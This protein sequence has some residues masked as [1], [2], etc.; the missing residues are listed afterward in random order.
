VEERGVRFVQLWFTDVL[1]TLKGFAITPAELE[2]ALEEG[3]TFDG[4][5]IQGYSRVQESDMLALPDPEVFQPVVASSNPGLLTRF[6]LTVTWAVA[7]DDSPAVSVTVT[8]TVKVP[9]AEY[10]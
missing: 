5:A 6:V 4:S 1:G 10:V 7:V 9:V 8:V 2:S 3:M